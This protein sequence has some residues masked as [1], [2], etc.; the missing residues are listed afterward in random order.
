M[1][2][3]F[4]YEESLEEKTTEVMNKCEKFLDLAFKVTGK[5]VMDILE[6]DAVTGAMIG[7]SIEL[8]KSSKEL[9]KMQAKVMDKMIGDLD[10]LKEM[11]KNLCKQ[12]EMLQQMLHDINKSVEKV[13]K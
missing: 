4:G 2:K 7:G 5:S 9:V 13:N 6:F 8:Y 11:N 3:L 1:S 12:N 10:E